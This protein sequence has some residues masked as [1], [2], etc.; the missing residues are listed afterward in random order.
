MGLFRGKDKQSYV[1]K[2]IHVV[3]QSCWK[4]NFYTDDYQISILNPDLSNE[5]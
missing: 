5:P 3:F 4:Y 2:K 1:E